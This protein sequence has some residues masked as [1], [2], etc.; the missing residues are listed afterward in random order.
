MATSIS[1]DTSQEVGVS[2]DTKWV[3]ALFFVVLF[4]P[5]AAYIG[6][7]MT[8]Y[9]LYL[10][11]M[12]IPMLQRALKDP[13][14]RISAVD[15]LMLAALAWQAFAILVRNGTE[16]LV[17]AFAQLGEF[18]LAY[19]L[20]R[21]YIRSAADFRF[22]FRCFLLALVVYL[23]FALAE[24]AHKR[25]LR[26]LWGLVLTQPGLP[27][28]ARVRFGLARVMG[29]FETFLVFGAYCAVGFSIVLYTF[30]DRFP[31]NVIYAGF[32]AFMAATAISTSSLLTMFVQSTMIAYAILFKWLKHK[33]IFAL[34]L[35]M[36]PLFFARTII[37]F[38]ITEVTYSQYTGESRTLHFVYGIREIIRH[39][40]F[41]VGMGGWD[42]P[43]WLSEKTDNYWLGL[44]LGRGAISFLLVVL[45]FGTHF[46]K[47]TMADG[48]SDNER[49]IRTGY[50]ISMTSVMVSFFYNS[51]FNASFVFFMMYIS[52]AAWIYD[53]SPPH[54]NL[55]LQAAAVRERRLNARRGTRP[56]RAQYS[57]PR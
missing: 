54:Q 9:R 20:G 8:P 18:Y 49:L 15:V 36:V 40:I 16:Q 42:N 44:A 6:I 3:I 34:I 35:A 26:D 41:G 43:Y 47:I 10:M 13:T 22:F 31:R 21:V 2:R 52:G 7:K 25:I 50:L 37:E 19:L 23:P 30:A 1:T 56:V 14:L 17:F 51:F 29:P 55:R 12:A 38:V 32:V 11:A 33:W 28:A 46:L 39:P 45:T 57:R 5:G 4:I 48:L 24:L 53:R 27:G